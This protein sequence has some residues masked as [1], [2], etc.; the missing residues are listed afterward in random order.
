MKIYRVHAQITFKEEYR[1]QA[2]DGHHP[3]DRVVLCK[4]AFDAKEFDTFKEAEEYFNELKAALLAKEP[5][6]LENRKGG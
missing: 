6:G 5:S 3:K 1:D 2:I 4:Q